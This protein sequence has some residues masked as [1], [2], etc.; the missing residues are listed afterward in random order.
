NDGSLLCWIQ[1][2]ADLVA[3][4]RPAGWGV[5]WSLGALL[6]L[7]I[8]GVAVTGAQGQNQPV[9][10]LDTL[11]TDMVKQG[12]MKLEVRGLGRLTSCRTAAVK[13]AETQMQ[14]VRQGQPAMIGFR[15]RKETVGGKVVAVHSEVANGTV[16]VDLVL[17]GVLP[18]G[19]N[20]EEPVDGT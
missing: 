19:I 13:V 20:L 9:V 17:D 12:D 1:R 10:K 5:V 4:H 6:L 8:V 16:T 18:S 11:W 14:D 15:N 3:A 7:G 2:L